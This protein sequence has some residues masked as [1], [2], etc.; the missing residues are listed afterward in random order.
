MPRVIPTDADDAI[1]LGDLIEMLDAGEFD[2]RD[3]ECFLSWGPALKRLANNRRFLADLVIEELK[4]HCANQVNE[5]PY[6]PQVIMLYTKSK[7]FGVRA[8]FWPAMSD[9]VVRSSGPDHFVYG[10]PH[11]H[12]FS[13]LTVGYLGPGYWSDYYEY[14]YD[15]VDGLPGES[16][17]LR[18]IEKSKLDLGKVMLYRAH[19][20][21]HLQ[22]PADE[23][24][25]SLNI[26]GSCHS[27]MFRDQYEFDVQRGVVKRILT[28]V[29]LGQLLALSAHFGGEKG[30]ELLDTYV[31]T[32]PSDRIRAQALKAQ[33][34]AYATANERIAHFERA[35]RQ[36]NR[37]V[38][39]A[40][41]LEVEKIERSR[42]WIEGQPSRLFAA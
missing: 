8:N 31:R 41:R 19:R 40:A 14:D 24:S 23:M 38:S 39:G 7:K 30:Q 35:A 1:E 32:H 37:F 28:S 21:V 2:A 22:F 27:L 42:G 11:D 36:G 17:P 20:D 3:E 10:L 29:A 4:T 33:A 5:N 15:R 34:S 13:F 18:F 25:V 9:S 6:G 26:T 12:N 16:V